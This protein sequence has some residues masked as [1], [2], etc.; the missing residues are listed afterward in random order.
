MRA[1]QKGVGILNMSND[2]RVAGR[3]NNRCKKDRN[4]PQKKE[5]EKLGSYFENK[6][7][8]KYKIE[9]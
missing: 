4:I 2:L 8:I 5:S 9:Q 6:K 3:G 1:M 7:I